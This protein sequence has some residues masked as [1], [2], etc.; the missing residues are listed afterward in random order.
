MA[1]EERGREGSQPLARGHGRPGSQ[2]SRSAETEPMATFERRRTGMRRASSV[3]QILRRAPFSL[4]NRPLPDELGLDHHRARAVAQRR[5][6]VEQ[7]ASRVAHA[8]HV[9]LA[10]V[11][12]RQ[13]ELPSSRDA[14]QARDEEGREHVE[15]A[16]LQ[17]E[18]ASAP[19]CDPPRRARPAGSK[20]TT[21]SRRA[22]SRRRFSM[23]SEQAPR[24][25]QRATVRSST[26]KRNSQAK[27]PWLLASG[28][29]LEGRSP[30]VF[31]ARHAQPGAPGQQVGVADAQGDLLARRE[32]QLGR[33]HGR[34]GADER[35]QQRPASLRSSHPR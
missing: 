27:K 10:V 8:Q 34:C 13:L 26:R 6:Q 12:H 30:V 35:R 24:G 18:L 15:R 3:S 14:L 28:H 4:T 33:V 20:V 25:S 22:P 21:W 7:L 19:L 9:A 17:L 31:F 16:G 1:I 5:R 32:R 23:R 11:E 29:E 2:A